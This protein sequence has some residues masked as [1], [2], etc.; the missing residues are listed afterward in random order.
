M[1]FRQ[2]LNDNRFLTRLIFLVGVLL[3]LVV[4]V[5]AGIYYWDRYV[6]L[7]DQSPIQRSLNQLEQAVRDNPK[8]IEARISLAEMYLVDQKYGDAIVQASQ[9]YKADPQNER[10]QFV[11]GVS[12]ASLGKF[13]Q[14]IPVLESFTSNRL[15]S[16]MANSDQA[17]EAA[18]YY[19]GSSY[20]E[21]NQSAE[22]IKA[23]TQA[24]LINKTDADAMYKLGQAYARSNQPDQAIVQY[25]KAVRFVPDFQ[26]AYQGMLEIYLTQN[27]TEYVHYAR[28]M[29]AYSQKDLKK[30][31][32]ELETSVNTLNNFAPLYVG[33]GSTYEELGETENAV[34]ALTKALALD[35]NNFTAQQALGRIQGK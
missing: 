14:A 17:L 18:L 24:L 3:L 12:Y 16:P 4:L 30:A 1:N 21:T 9:V 27:K 31:K 25:D 6:H 26:E 11:L 19:L 22:A 13:S 2:R 10:S 33:L 20:I 28:G 7:G 34:Q 23:L 15:T 8:D 29:L 32:S 35:P 5:F